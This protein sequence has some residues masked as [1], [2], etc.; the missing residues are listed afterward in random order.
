MAMVV[1]SAHDEDDPAA[2]QRL[3]ARRYFGQRR[4]AAYRRGKTAVYGL[5]ATF[6]LLLAYCGTSLFVGWYGLGAMAGRHSGSALPYGAELSFLGNVITLGANCLPYLC[7]LLLA[8]TGSIDESLRL[9]VSD[10]ILT[11]ELWRSWL[12]QAVTLIAAPRVAAVLV[13]QAVMWIQLLQIRHFALVNNPVGSYDGNEAAYLRLD[14]AFLF[15][16]GLELFLTTVLMRM[17]FTYPG[18]T[19]RTLLLCTFVAT[20]L[21]LKKLA[22]QGVGAIWEWLELLPGNGEDI[23]FPIALLILLALCLTSILSMLRSTAHYAQRNAKR[24]I[25]RLG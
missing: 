4:G 7:W 25:E 18:R 2:E 11:A 17:C 8:D 5:C 12:L 16:L 13:S 10:G 6:V 19:A 9:A 3:A 14:A 23:A 21:V 1:E 15:C 20:A 22:F 24:I